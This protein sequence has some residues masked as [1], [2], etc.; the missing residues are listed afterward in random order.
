MTKGGYNLKSSKC[1]QHD[2]DLND[3]LLEIQALTKELYESIQQMPTRGTSL[4]NS[5]QYKTRAPLDKNEGYF[6]DKRHNDETSKR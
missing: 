3:E 2:K 4:N 1:A 6:D 5:G